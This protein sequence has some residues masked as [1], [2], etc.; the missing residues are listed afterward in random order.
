ME[1]QRTSTSTSI[2]DVTYRGKT[3][4]NITSQLKQNNVP[5]GVVPSTK[6]VRVDTSP[7]KLRADAS[8]MYHTSGGY[9]DNTAMT[10]AAEAIN[11]ERDEAIS[12]F[13]DGNMS[14]DE[15]ADTF[16]R[17]LNKFRDACNENDFPTVLGLGLY[18]DEGLS[19]AFCSDFRAQILKQAVQRND[20]EGRQYITGEIDTQ[21]NWKYYNSDYYFLSED[22]LAEIGRAHV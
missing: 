15:L 8:R 19:E 3:F 21:R 2:G 14:Q 10:A 22:A 12:Q 6:G 11:Q 4:K 9:G 7:E 5:D 1:V 13:L 17:L 20:D 18:Q 16:E